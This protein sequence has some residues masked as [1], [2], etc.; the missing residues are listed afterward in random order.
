MSYRDRSIIFG[1]I[2]GIFISLSNS[3]SFVEFIIL[4]IPTSVAAGT[5]FYWLGIKFNGKNS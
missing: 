1:A 5:L 3:T 2:M 4:F